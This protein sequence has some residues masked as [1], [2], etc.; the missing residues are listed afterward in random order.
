ME[1]RSGSAP[2]P[3]AATKGRGSSA[4]ESSYAAPAITRSSTAIMAHLPMAMLASAIGASTRAVAALH[5]STGTLDA[6]PAPGAG[7]ESLQSPQEIIGGE[8]WP[9]RLGHVELGVGYLPEQEVRDAQ[10]AAGPDH[11][12]DVGHLGGIE[13]T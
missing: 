13:V 2:A 8:V 6:A 7:P 1:S 11:Q 10:L 9:K 12:V 4:R 3:R 5:R